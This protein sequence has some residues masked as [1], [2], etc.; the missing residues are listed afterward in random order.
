MQINFTLIEN[1]SLSQYR[2]ISDAI[3]LEI[4]SG[5]LKPGTKLPTVREISDHFKVS[6]GTSKRAYDYLNHLGLI[7]MIQGR[8]TFVIYDGVNNNHDT[9]QLETYI[10]QFLR[11][12]EK[13]GFSLSTI[14][15]TFPRVLREYSILPSKV[16]VALIDCNPEALYFMVRQFRSFDSLVSTSFLLTEIGPETFENKEFDLLITT[17]SHF[18]EVVKKLGNSTPILPISL[19]PSKETIVKLAQIPDTSH[20]GICTKSYRFARIACHTYTSI[21]NRESPPIFLFDLDDELKE[22]VADKDILIVPELYHRFANKAQLKILETF[23]AQ[24]GTVQEFR[25]QLDNGSMLYIASEIK[26]K[27]DSFAALSK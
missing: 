11:E 14:E 15:K 9:N 26:A 6:I 21:T 12:M 2:R 10:H 23:I 5:R 20:V 7:T 19:E 8:G 16:K 25:Y 4:E 24:G 27:L 18:E 1:P 22:F 13:N 17:Q 3:V